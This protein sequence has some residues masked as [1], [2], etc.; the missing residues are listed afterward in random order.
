MRRNVPGTCVQLALLWGLS[1]LGG[2][3][4]GSVPQFF[5]FV[6]SAATILCAKR[7]ASDTAL[8]ARTPA[9]ALTDARKRAA[10][11]LFG[12]RCQQCH[13]DDGKAE[14]QRRA[15]PELPDFTNA[16]WHLRRRDKQLLVSI[17]DGKGQEMPAFR[18]KVTEDQA[19]DLVA[20]VR[21]FR[22]QA[23]SAPPREDPSASYF[24]KRF[25]ELRSEL[26][27][28]KKQF[29]QLHKKPPRKD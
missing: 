22:P 3:G 1:V 10:R 6:A 15:L 20:L 27:D 11:E 5:S 23:G 8:P 4:G 12:K 14:A 26:A 2:C 19:R 18:N 7:Q 16:N 25:E 24:D 29:Y 9:P 17:L 13:G 21:A 28:L